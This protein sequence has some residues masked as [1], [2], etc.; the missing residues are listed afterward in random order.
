MT[1]EFFLD[2]ILLGNQYCSKGYIESETDALCLC[3]V[4]HAPNMKDIIK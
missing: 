4:L 1:R 3:G 2:V